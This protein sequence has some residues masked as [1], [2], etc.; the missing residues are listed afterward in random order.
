MG[1]FHKTVR[2]DRFVRGK[3]SPSVFNKD[4][5]AFGFY[6]RLLRVV[7]LCEKSIDG[8]EFVKT[9][10]RSFLI[11]AGIAAGHVLPA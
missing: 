3:T 7:V 8:K 6:R 11:V 2:I 9:L 10:I 5:A 4:E 1:F